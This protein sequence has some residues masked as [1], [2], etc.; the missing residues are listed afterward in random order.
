MRFPLG[1]YYLK[2]LSTDYNHPI[3]ENSPKLVTLSGSKHIL[4]IISNQIC[5]RHQP[6]KK[7]WV[8]E[9]IDMLTTEQKY[10]HHLSRIC[11]RE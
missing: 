11:C 1:Y 3:G 10:L 6:R 7:T 8:S 2:K 4:M 9:I 5:V